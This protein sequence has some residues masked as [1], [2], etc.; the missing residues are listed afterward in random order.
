MGWARHGLGAVRAG[1]GQGW[2]GY[3]QV[4]SSFASM[5]LTLARV[6]D[7]HSQVRLSPSLSKDQVGGGCAS[8]RSHR[9]HLTGA[10]SIPAR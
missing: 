1:R 6:Q 9:S 5:D 3:H 7:S 4:S 10:S 2:R 8:T